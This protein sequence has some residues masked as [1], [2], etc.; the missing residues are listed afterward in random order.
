VT[1]EEARPKIICT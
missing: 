1:K